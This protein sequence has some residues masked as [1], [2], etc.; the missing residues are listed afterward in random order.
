MIVAR[1]TTSPDGRGWHWFLAWA[2]SG[3][4]LLFSF[5]TGFSIGLFV[6]PF[7]AV[8]LIWSARRAP[9]AAEALGVALGCG[10][11]VL[12]LASLSGGRAWYATGVALS[13]GAVFAYAAVLTR[14]EHDLAR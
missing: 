4:L 3:A 9:H 1:R 8:L 6:L 2:G 11:V 10:L 7:A 13:L 14:R 12:L 5:F